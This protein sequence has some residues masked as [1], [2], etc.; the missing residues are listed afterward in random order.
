MIFYH[1]PEVKKILM[2]K[3]LDLAYALFSIIYLC[4][5][6]TELSLSWLFKTMP[7]LILVIAVVL[8]TTV[9]NRQYLLIALMFSVCGDILLDINYF[10]FGVGAFL[11]A[12]LCYAK[13]FISSWQGFATRWPASVALVACMLVMLF[14]LLPNLGDLQL[15]VIAYLLAIGLMGLAAIQSSQVFYW[16]V[17]GAIV[18]II[19]DSLIAVDKF[20]YP[21]PMRSYG[22]M[23]TYYLAQ[24]M[25]ITGLLTRGQP[26][27]ELTR[28]QPNNKLTSSRPDTNTTQ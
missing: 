18:F 24:W 19:S 8:K 4:T 28:G 25:L 15:P 9:A 1:S 2:T 13:I 12:Q 27:K 6:S 3:I 20:L 23:I 16:S 26:N 17:L 7:I 21:L 5:L 11:L 10:I 14:L 22:V